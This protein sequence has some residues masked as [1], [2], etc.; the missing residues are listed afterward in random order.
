MA[1]I[2]F[3][4]QKLFRDDYT[5]LH[6]R[7]YAY[8]S[9]IAAGPWLISVISVALINLLVKRLGGLEE[10]ESQLFIVTISYSFIFS[11]VLSGGWQLVVTRFLAD[12]FYQNKLDI[13]TPTF[14][15]I[16][17]IVFVTSLGAAILFYIGS[18]LPFSY[19]LISTMLFLMI[20]Q[21]WL[22]MVFLSAAK[23]YQIISYAFL[24]GSIVSVLGVFVLLATP[25]PFEQHE[26]V[27]NVL[28]GFTVGVGITLLMLLAVLLRTFPARTRQNHY[29]FLHYVDK[30]PSLLAV[31]FLYNLGIWMDKILIWLGP[32]GVYV[33]QTFRFSP[34]Y[35]NAVFLAYFSVIPSLVLFVVA[36]E[37]EFYSRY[38][39]FYGYVT[40]GG[41]LEM[42]MRAKKR[43]VEVLWYQMLRLT[44]LQGVCTLS[45]IIVADFLFDWLKYAEMTTDIFQ[46]YA[47]GA[48]TS[49]IMLMCILIM[50]YF[51]DRRGA[52]Y[53]SVLF[54]AANTVM[55]LVVIPPGLDYYGLNYF[56]ASLISF[57]YCGWRLLKY[58]S[59]IEVHTF[60]TQGI[61]EK[62]VRGPFTRLAEKAQR[63]F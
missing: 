17:R 45:L 4:L 43:M 33:E 41:T 15:G 19:K 6:I 2:G 12:H 13:I 18:P 7:A 10:L 51:E 44:K 29:G 52:L 21:I 14:T 32:A 36:V 60:V 57:A 48:M 25:L 62:E 20:G 31:G 55:T 56:L 40:N 50:L 38:R 27:T 26:R 49:T 3:K 53:A 47:L 5:S 8:A 22:C 24:T 63:L 23:N 28:I 1:G 30:Y 59:R 16:S 37:T 9:F 54:F 61:L 11:Q 46:I 58:L 42:I 34:I 35:D 39:E